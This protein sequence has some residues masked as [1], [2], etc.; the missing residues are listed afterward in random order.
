MAKH[1]EIRIDNNAATIYGDLDFSNVMSIYQQSQKLFTAPQS[2]IIIDF[3][4]LKSTNSAALALIINWMRL[5][6][7][8]K[9]NIQFRNLSND[10]MSLAKSSGL[11]KVIA[12]A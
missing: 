7:K 4:E 9:K 8:Q 11:D 1:A 2:E 3:I 10:I 5:A 12:H 6:K